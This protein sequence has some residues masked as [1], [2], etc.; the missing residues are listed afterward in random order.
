MSTLSWSFVFGFFALSLG[1][2]LAT[3]VVLWVKR[4]SFP[5]MY[6]LLVLAVLLACLPTLFLLPVGEPVDGA[7]FVKET[8]VA[9]LA[10][11]TM[12]LVPANTQEPVQVNIAITSPEQT[13]NT[14][15]PTPVGTPGMPL[16]KAFGPGY[17]VFILAQINAN[18]FD[19]TPQKQ[20]VRAFNPS[21]SLQ[22]TLT[23]KYTGYQ[24]FEV[25]VTGR[26]VP[27]S[28]GA[29]VEH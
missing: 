3:I 9:D 11:Q 10:I 27:R 25:R 26:W 28:G 12:V 2:A 17:D 1:A 29:A 14:V 20:L 16:V 6:G 24:S 4:R 19:V 5:R 18:A 23:P 15:Q 7:L 21:S 13:L 22:W 8:D